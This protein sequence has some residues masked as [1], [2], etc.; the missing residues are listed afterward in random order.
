MSLSKKKGQPVDQKDLK[1][2]KKR[3]MVHSLQVISLALLSTL[4]SK[5]S[6]SISLMTFWK[7]V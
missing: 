3:K 5:N 1:A 6:W 2:A 4:W 7:K